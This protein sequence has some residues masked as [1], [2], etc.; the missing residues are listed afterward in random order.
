MAQAK[1]ILELPIY[2]DFV[3][4]YQSRPDLFIREICGTALTPDQLRICQLMAKPKAR[5]S[6]VSGT[7]CFG[8]NTPILM[9]DG[10]VKMVQDVDIGDKLI[11]DDGVTH[12]DVLQQA[13]GRES[14]YRFRLGGGRE[15]VFNS[16][17][18]LTLV[19]SVDG[20]GYK[21][22][23]IVEMTVAEYLELSES[24]KKQL[25]FFKQTVTKFAHSGK[26][27]PIPPYILGLWLTSGSANSPVFY[28][29]NE[30]DEVGRV[31]KQY[32]DD[33]GFE[34]SVM[35]IG[36]SN[37]Y[38]LKSPEGRNAF[39][40]AL[41][42]LGLQSDKKIPHI[43]KSASLKDR[44]ELIA[45]LIDGDGGLRK[46]KAGYDFI[47]KERAISE[48]L[49]YLCN[50]SGCSAVVREVERYCTYKGQRR[51]GVYYRVSVTKGIDK[52]PVRLT[53]K[54]G[55]QPA[56]PNRWFRIAEVEYIG[57]DD[58]YGFEL[59]GNGRFIEPDGFV[60]HN[61][62][63][64]RTMAGL[65]LWHLTCFPVAKYAGKYERGSNT[66]IAAPV[67][68][69]VKD[70]VWKE[71]KGII[72]S[73]QVR[74]DLRWLAD[75][76]VLKEETVYMSGFKGEWFIT[77]VALQAGKDGAV[78]IAGKHRFYQLIMIDEAAGVSDSHFKVINGTQTQPANRTFMASQGVK[79]SGFFYETHH[80]LSREN[81]GAWDTVQMSSINS[82]FADDEWIKQVE[83]QAGGKD[84][85]EY[86]IRVLG[87]FAEN[88]NENLLT[89]AELEEVM[90]DKADKNL[91]AG[92]ENWGYLMLVDVGAG[93]Y[94]DDTVCT[95]AKVS[96]SADFGSEAR[97]VEYTKIPLKTNSKD[98]DDSA[99]LI[100]EIYQNLSNATVLVDVGGIGMA[101]AKKLEKEGVRVKRVQWGNPCFRKEYRERFFNQRACAMVRFRDAVRQGR[102]SITVPMDRQL[103]ET[104]LLQGS[105]L[106]YGFT[107]SGTLRYKM[108]SKDKMRAEGIKSP[109]I[110]DT[111]TFAFLEDAYYNVADDSFSGSDNNAALLETAVAMF[112]DV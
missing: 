31:I 4:R 84:A 20:A 102:V 70:G 29:N 46:C 83:L 71:M 97:R 68:K 48:G 47:H 6:A 58:F 35:P 10:R 38:Y 19:Q 78:S 64:T 107:D 108:W 34:L 85:A 17:H 66:Y 89:R 32:A 95:V 112:E 93:E 3:K 76:V 52:I 18:I 69:Q 111:F 57:E 51:G 99:G 61:T 105:R 40:I 36:K 14:M 39:K 100:I 28:V 87:E 53:R 101:L 2:V 44:L 98:I 41:K 8:I 81:G 62:G 60:L 37:R 103:R 65:A 50:L 49:A 7:G 11:G 94:R 86:R 110:I 33:A 96:G 26:K 106:P 88:E 30:D 91:F 13:R 80:N 22:G 45:G 73:W 21:R 54:K 43:Y 24:R 67:I 109:D 74:D 77:S 82:P 63:K 42:S 23:D 104:I 59:S 16:G 5:V 79:T 92:R 90:G 12:V 1:S 9:H 75:N 55:K 15:F 25:Y 27:F 56:K 72:A